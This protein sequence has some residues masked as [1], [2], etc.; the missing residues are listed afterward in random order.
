VAQVNRIIDNNSTNED[1]DVFRTAVD[2][3]LFFE[4]DETLQLGMLSALCR[5]EDGA[6]GANYSQAVK[7][8]MSATQQVLGVIENIQQG[9]AAVQNNL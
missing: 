2:S 3:G 8:V 6:N 4:T 7:T 5:P 1:P 9:V